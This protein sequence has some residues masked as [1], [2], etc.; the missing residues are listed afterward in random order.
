MSPRRAARPSAE[1]K[2]LAEQTSFVLAYGTKSMSLSE[3]TTHIGIRP[4]SNHDAD[5]IKAVD[6]VL[7]GDAWEGSDIIGGFRIVAVKDAAI[8]IGSAL[9][10]LRLDASVAVGTHVFDLADGAG[11]FVPTGELYVEFQPKVAKA[12][13]E[14]TL[15]RFKL[16]LK[17]A[18]GDNGFVVATTKASPNPIK[19]AAALQAD[20]DNVLIAEPDLAT[21]VAAAGFML[22]VDD[23]LGE[24]WHLRNTGRHR[25]TETGFKKGADARVID[26][27][28]ATGSLG[29]P[30]TVIA[31][32]DDGFDL[33]HPDLATPNKVVNPWDFTRRNNSPLPAGGDWHGTA[34]A[35]VALANSGAGGVVG[36][37]PSCTLMPVRWGRNLSD[38]EIEG[39]FDYVAVKG[40]AVVSC[41]WGARPS[42]FPLST[43]AFRAIERCATTGRGGL[44]CVV[45]FAAGNENHDIEDPN[46]T[47][48]NGFAIHPNVIA[49]A[50][51][52][53][54]DERSDYSNFGSAISICAPSSGSGGWGILTADV[55]GM[56]A[57]TG[58]PM[59]Y[60]AGSYTYDFGGTSSA[61]PLVAGVAA[62]VLSIDP[63]LTAAQ[64]KSLLQESARKIGAAGE[65]NDQGHSANFGYGCVDA[66][67]ACAIASGASPT[68]TSAKS[69]RA[70]RKQP[71]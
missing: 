71:A 69:P 16:I 65:Y 38:A 55:T 21:K 25:G 29:S 17:E 58:M 64:V 68:R 42:Y 32:I 15:D 48:L 9:D 33:S 28:I 67:A 27:W 46:G 39:W 50:A 34:C 6:R 23:L 37:A 49:V 66:A 30:S 19:V 36:A 24:Q 3:S 54:R 5:A 14:A 26:S 63:R 45:V 60:D 59:G 35:G 12:R 62:L 22:P 70:R 4:R 51:S 44:G 47:T 2:K 52:T 53:S 57:L 56:D 7:G 31:V 11:S 41:S 10:Q 61:C 20:T 40:A 8:D 1:M 13:R 43:R 18:R